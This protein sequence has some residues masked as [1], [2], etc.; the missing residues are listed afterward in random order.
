MLMPAAQTGWR[1][2]STTAGGLHDAT[3]RVRASAVRRTS[4]GEWITESQNEQSGLT[5]SAIR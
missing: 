1:W 3:T 4:S 5:P 2:P